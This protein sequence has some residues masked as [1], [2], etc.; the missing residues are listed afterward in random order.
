MDDWT[1]DLMLGDCLEMLKELP[2]NS[3]ARI[4]AAKDS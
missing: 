4:M 2:D 3:E 1:I